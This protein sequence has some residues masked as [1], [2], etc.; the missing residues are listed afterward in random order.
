VQESYTRIG[1]IPQ[2]GRHLMQQAVMLSP[3]QHQFVM[4]ATA[5]RTD[6]L[7]RL[8]E[9]P[10]GA[11]RP[12]E[13]PSSRPAAPPQTDSIARLIEATEAPVAD[14]APAD[15]PAI[16][17]AVV[18]DAPAPVAPPAADRAAEPRFEENA[19]AARED[20]LAIS[21]RDNDPGEPA[22]PILNVPVPRANPRLAV[23]ARNGDQPIAAEPPTEA[24]KTATVVRKPRPVRRVRPAAQ[25][26]VPA[27]TTT[28]FPDNNGTWPTMPG[29][30]N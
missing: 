9:I 1:D 7:Q 30:V 2:M 20:R 23:L 15:K 26:P 10:I 8:L 27:S 11:A 19:V 16:R 21:A 12:A 24:A 13:D 29:R 14:V 25:R 3:E 5:R 17:P 22:V 6:E 18:P 4:A 28:L